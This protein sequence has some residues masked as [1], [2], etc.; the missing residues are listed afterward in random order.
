MSAGSQRAVVK[1]L[2]DSYEFLS[3]TRLGSGD[4][5]H[6]ELWECYEQYQ[7]AIRRARSIS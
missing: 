1:Q 2:A 4:D 6:V 7:R 5:G 3:N